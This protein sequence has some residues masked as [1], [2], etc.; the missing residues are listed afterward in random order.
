MVYA[1]I[2]CLSPT[3]PPAKPALTQNPS[4]KPSHA[5]NLLCFPRYPPQE[6]FALQENDLATRLFPT[7]AQYTDEIGSSAPSS[8]VLSRMSQAQVHRLHHRLSQLPPDE[9]ALMEAAVDEAV[10]KRLRPLKELQELDKKVQVGTDPPATV[11][12]RAVLLLKVQYDVREGGSAAGVLQGWRGRG[13]RWRG[14]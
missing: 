9:A 11:G 12:I 5:Q 8:A 13:W 4:S 14:A 6:A 1:V 2:R 10:H 7:S 3:R